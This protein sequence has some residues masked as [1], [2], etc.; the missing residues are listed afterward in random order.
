M[1]SY[2]HINFQQN[3]IQQVALEVESNFPA[4]PVAGRLVFKD[5]VLYICAEIA[6]GTPVWIPLTHEINTHIHV[7]NSP[8]WTWNIQH[9]LNLGTP[10]V[11][12][13]DQES[14][15]M[16]IPNAIDVIDADNVQ[17]TFNTAIAGRAI[18]MG[19]ILSGH[20]NDRPIYGYEHTQTNLATV[21]TVNHGLGYYP[22][23]R[24]FVGATEILPLAISHPSLF[25]TVI[26][27]SSP[28]TGIA[29]FV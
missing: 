20:G 16:V 15:S 25:T 1:K 27:F 10:L 2:G 14:N 9:G 17:V 23:A 11:Q 8:Q 6:L 24:V 18:V 5:R 29:R 21:W 19:G 28:Q 12:V 3:Q 13:Y 22:D 7:E 4:Q 26:E